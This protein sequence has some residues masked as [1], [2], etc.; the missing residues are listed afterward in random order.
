VTQR[1]ND[2]DIS[3]EMNENLDDNV[4]GDY[5]S[6]LTNLNNKKRKHNTNKSISTQPIVSDDINNQ[7]SNE[8]ETK[9]DII[10]NADEAVNSRPSAIK[11]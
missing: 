3:D 5:S 8:S 6:P 7:D 2:N 11:K 9:E 4:N 1:P 10:S